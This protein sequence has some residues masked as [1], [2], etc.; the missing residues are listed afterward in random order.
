VC[1]LVT[2]LI[3]TVG[4]WSFRRRCSLET[5]TDREQEKECPVIKEAGLGDS[6]TT[7]VKE[8][9]RERGSVCAC[10]CVCVCGAGA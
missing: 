2:Q 9:A 10:L 4:E 6:I 5:K 7:V 3:L 1:H 8:K